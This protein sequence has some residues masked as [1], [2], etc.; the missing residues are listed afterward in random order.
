[1]Y[2]IMQNMRPRRVQ[3]FEYA[4]WHETHDRKIDRTMIGDV[5]VSTIFCG[6][7]QSYGCGPPLIFETRVSGRAL[8][9]ETRR[10]ATLGEAKR[11]HHE[12][13]DAVQASL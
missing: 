13:V 6:V 12:I 1:M 11:G 2:Y 4:A 10:Y 8:D 5:L 3:C 9:G 7:D